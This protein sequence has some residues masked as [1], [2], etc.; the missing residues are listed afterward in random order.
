[1]ID[2]L[3][4]NERIIE[5][6][7]VKY[8]I[9][10]GFLPQEVAEKVS[11]GIA[12]TSF[13][14]LSF[15]NTADSLEFN[16]NGEFA[17]PSGY[18][19]STITNNKIYYGIKES[20]AYTTGG[21][22]CRISGSDYILKI[23]ELKTFNGIN[24]VVFIYYQDGAINNN[25][26]RFVYIVTTTHLYAICLEDTGTIYTYKLPNKININENIKFSSIHFFEKATFKNVYEIIINDYYISFEKITTSL[27]T[28][29]ANTPQ[30]FLKLSCP[31][32]ILSYKSNSSYYVLNIT[33]NLKQNETI[34]LSNNVFLCRQNSPS[35]YNI[36][37][38]EF[39]KYGIELGN[40]FSI[41]L[42]NYSD[43]QKTID[44]DFVINK[45]FKINLLNNGIQ[46]GSFNLNIT[47]I[48][49]TITKEFINQKLQENNFQ[50][51]EYIGEDILLSENDLLKEELNIDVKENF[52]EVTINCLDLDTSLIETYKELVRVD[53]KVITT[54]DIPD[55][56]RLFLFLEFNNSL[57]YN[58]IYTKDTYDIKINYKYGETL[59]ET[60]TKTITKEDKVIFAKNITGY[61]A[62]ET[63]K[64]I[65]YLKREYVFNYKSNLKS[66][67]VIC[68]IKD[69]ETI[70]KTETITTTT[71]YF[72]APT[73]TGYLPESNVIF[74]TDADT[75]IVYYVENNPKRIIKLNFLNTLGETIKPFENIEISLNKDILEVPS[76]EGYI[77]LS[78][79]YISLTKQN[80]EYDLIYDTINRSITIVYLDSK[81]KREFNRRIEI[82][83]NK[84]DHFFITKIDGYICPK[85]IEIN[86]N[87]NTYN[88]ECFKINDVR[89]L[90]INCIDKDTNTVLKRETLEVDYI[91]NKIYKT[92]PVISGYETETTHLILDESIEEYNVYYQKIKAELINS[93]KFYTNNG[94]EDEDILKCLKL[95]DV[96]KYNV[97]DAQMHKAIEIL[98]LKSADEITAL[99]DGILNI[100][101]DTS[102]CFQKA[103]Y[104]LSLANKIEKEY[105]DNKYKEENPNINVVLFSGYADR[106]IS[107]RNSG[108]VEND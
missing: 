85:I 80:N 68:K 3:N 101:K 42:L 100:Q 73:I 27:T 13:T 79:G 93:I 17:F 55:Y 20:G 91:L 88:I 78:N 44:L 16:T 36:K 51:Y 61:V 97:E 59:L 71:G 18:N 9:L 108:G 1:M 102:I 60:E 52:K 81:T 63:F 96:L 64:P 98:W 49:T 15:T 38:N 35:S 72:N 56:T 74:T 70:L 95:K 48:P 58:F 4:T 69:I 92:I 47:D 105:L 39:K 104:H 82:V 66:I 45:T 21:P 65:E 87:T 29:T 43:I 7:E 75:Y 24:D 28:T 11:N 107:S 14:G 83:G 34:K 89:N 33:L 2:L 94:W 84:M 106:R 30:S 54:K 6:R 5:E 46:S 12:N 25:N 8:A 77:H 32:V 41:I 23:N 90:V 31:D 26:Q 62:S 50:A 22:S 53:S 99:N 57:E 40:I 10:N 86:K 37:N 67:N 76:I 103:N 19:M